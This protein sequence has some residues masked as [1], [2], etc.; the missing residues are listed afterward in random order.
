MAR[1]PA[2]QSVDREDILW[3]AAEVLRRKGHDATTMKDIAAQVNL[4]AASLYHHFKNKDFLLLS[5]LE[6]GLDLAT[7]R[8]ERIVD[9]DM[10]SADKFAA[11]IRSHIVSVTEN[12]AIGAAMVFEIRAILNVNKGNRNVEGKTQI[13]YAERRNQF[14]ERRDYF[15]SL[16]HDVLAAGIEAGEFRPVDAAIVTKTIL[17]AHNWVGVWFREGGRLSGRRSGGLFFVMA[18]FFR[19]VSALRRAKV[20]GESLSHLRDMCRTIDAH[21]GTPQS[22]ANWSDPEDWIL[23]RLCGDSRRIAWRLWRESEGLINPANLK[24]LKSLCQ[25]HSLLSYWE[26]EIV[27]N[28]AGKRFLDNDKD[29]IFDMDEY[30]GIMIIL[31]EVAVNGPGESREFLSSFR[32]IAGNIRPGSLTLRFLQVSLRGS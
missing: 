31:R 29:F 28:R 1:K 30:E 27:L 10:S 16:F 9:S 11:M 13:E 32:T 14:F 15:E 26:D 4:T 6:V 21:R 2:D 5:V 17:G 3:A 18:D 24:G 23:E 25:T 19:R 7:E 8:L 12:V 20:P 22:T